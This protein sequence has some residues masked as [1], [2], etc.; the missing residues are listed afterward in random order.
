MLHLLFWIAAFAWSDQPEWTW[1]TYPD[2]GFKILTPCAM[3]DHVND[4]PTE[5][6]VISYHQISG[7][8]LTDAQLPMSF[9]VDHYRLPGD[10]Q[11]LSET[12]LSEFFD[13]T[14]DPIMEALGGTIVYAD[15]NS[16]GGKDVCSWK[17][18]YRNGDCIIRG[19]S[20]IIDGRYYGMQAFGWAKHEPEELMNKFFNSFRL[21][22]EA[23]PT[24]IPS[25]TSTRKMK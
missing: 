9:V 10:Q 11:V 20:M 5:R 24:T 2:L 12:E 25:R 8:S 1:S 4:F 23:L 3:E 15:I 18:T 16:N 19:E 21:I 17:A 14:L 13:N 22:E 7:G 6:E